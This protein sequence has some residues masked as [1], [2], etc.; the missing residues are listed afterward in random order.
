MARVWS[1]EPHCLP[2]VPSTSAVVGGCGE[3]WLKV[4]TSGVAMAVERPCGRQASL[5][6]LDIFCGIFIPSSFPFA[7]DMF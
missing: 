1:N 2:S 5:Q 4:H 3:G 6:S 7:L